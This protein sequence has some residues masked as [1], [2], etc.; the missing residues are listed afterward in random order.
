MR[1]FA[2]HSIVVAVAWSIIGHPTVK[3]ILGRTLLCYKVMSP[4]TACSLQAPPRATTQPGSRTSSLTSLS[5][6]RMRRPESVPPEVRQQTA[7]HTRPRHL[8]HQQTTSQARNPHPTSRS[9]VPLRPCGRLQAP[10]RHEFFDRS[11]S[12]HPPSGRSSRTLMR[13]ASRGSACQ[14][15]RCFTRGMCPC[16]GAFTPGEPRRR[17]L[18]PASPRRTPLRHPL[19]QCSCFYSEALTGIHA[20]PAHAYTCMH[21]HAYTRMQAGSR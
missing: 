4:G 8:A 1:Q 13:G 16:G 7:P 14:T 21:T 10:R 12:P 17:L 19:S 2:I 11:T 18:H 20:A 5:H 6:N 9:S 15:G 3:T